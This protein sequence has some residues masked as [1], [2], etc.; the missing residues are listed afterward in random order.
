MTGAARVRDATCWCG[1]PYGLGG[2]ERR[3]HQ[4]LFAHRPEPARVGSRETGVS[5]RCELGLH[6]RCTGTY[7]RETCC[8]CCCHQTGLTATST[9]EVSVGGAGAGGAL[10]LLVVQQ[11]WAWAIAF[12]WK[13]VELRTTN[14]AG[15]YRGPVA[16]CAGRQEDQDAYGHPAMRRALMAAGMWDEQR[17]AGPILMRGMV[18]AVVDLVDVHHAPATGTRCACSP[19]RTV[20]ASG[21]AAN[22]HLLLDNAR[23]LVEPMPVRGRQGLQ[24]ADHEFAATIWAGVR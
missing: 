4:V 5:M 21:V 3:R 11:P 10:R 14:V 17:Q 19:A 2:D 16:I 18:L 9:S 12:G 24:K 23:A 13:T 15:S 7:T 8:T 22:W 20:W 1:Q 6:D